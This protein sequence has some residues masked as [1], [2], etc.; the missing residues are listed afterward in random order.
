MIF[1]CGIMNHSGIRMCSSLWRYRYHNICSPASM[2]VTRLVEALEFVCGGSI[3]P[4]SQHD[5]LGLQFM[6]C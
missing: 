5:I 2:G 6:F 3:G 4:K 1:A